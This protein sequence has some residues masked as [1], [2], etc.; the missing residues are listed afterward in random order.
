MTLLQMVTTEL[1]LILMLEPAGEN[2]AAAGVP[3][4]VR[5]GDA[6]VQHLTIQ[7]IVIRVAERR[8]CFRIR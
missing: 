6:V 7:R 8:G 1:F 3:H 4:Q 2:S 5:V